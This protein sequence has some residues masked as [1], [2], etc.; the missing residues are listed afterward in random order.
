MEHQFQGILHEADMS[1]VAGP[2]TDNA[3]GQGIDLEGHTGRA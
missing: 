2:P 3:P 1:R